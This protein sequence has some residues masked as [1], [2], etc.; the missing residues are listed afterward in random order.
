MAS[1]WENNL[2]AHYFSYNVVLSLSLSQLTVPGFEYTSRGFAQSKK[3]A[4]TAAAKDFCG[5]LIGAGLIPAESLP[6][7]V[8]VSMIIAIYL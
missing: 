7:S 2:Y 4:E 6:D 5:Y 3:D 8:F 1:S